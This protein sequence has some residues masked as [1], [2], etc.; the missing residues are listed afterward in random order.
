MVE[1]SVSHEA[2]TGAEVA[3]ASPCVGSGSGSHGVH[4]VGYLRG[5][6]PAGLDCESPLRVVCRYC[7]ASDVMRCGNHRA[8][9]CEPCAT[10]YRHRVR[11]V[12]AEG[13]LHHSRQGLLYLATF[14]AP[15]ADEHL[16]W[17]PNWN[18]KDPRPVCGCEGHMAAGLGVW[19]AGASRCWNRLRTSL[20][21]DLPEVAYFRAAETQQRG[22]LHHHVILWSP[23]ALNVLEVQRLALQ[24]GYGCVV[25]LDPIAAG[26]VRAAAYV[27]KYVS[28]STDQRDEVPWVA[29]VLDRETGEVR[30]MHTV[31]TFRTWSASQNWGMTMKVLREAVRLAAQARAA[32]L[33]ELAETRPANHQG[34]VMAPPAS[35]DPP[36]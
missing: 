10:R 19:N 29:D 33:L 28:K 24:A 3:W 34:D 32:R 21:R 22:A 13:M 36:G 4:V 9:K 23:R 35:G 20:K 12:A 30:A 14:T 6:R 31:P 1:T 18:R 5:P 25:D 2:H 26:D 17:V 16:Q 15:A 27:S 8:S 11:R 7:P